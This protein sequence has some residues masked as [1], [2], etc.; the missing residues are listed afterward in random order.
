[1]G[2]Y[3]SAVQVDLLNGAFKERV[4]FSEGLN[5]VSGANG[6]GKTKLLSH[7]RDNF[8]NQA[9]VEI[10]QL[11]SLP[12][13]AT[14]ARVQAINPR[15]NSQRQSVEQI[16]NRF[17]SENK[18]FENALNEFGQ[19]SIN[20][21]T[22]QP[23]TSLAELFLLAFERRRMDGS[24][25]IRRMEEVAEDFNSVIA[26]IF[27]GYRINATWD[28]QLGRPSIRVQK[29]ATV[30]MDVDQ[31]S[32]GEQS[33]LALALHV[34]CSRDRYDVLLIDEPE[35]HLNWS[36]ERRLFALLLWLAETYDKQ[37]IV[38]THSRVVFDSE[39]ADRTIFLDWS[40]AG[41]VSVSRVPSRRL[42][43]LLAGEAVNLLKIGEF[44]RPTFFVED[45]AHEIA[46]KAIAKCLEVAV[47][48][49][50]CGSSSNVKSMYR[51]SKA[52]GG[53]RNC[54][55]VVDGDNQGN[56]YPGEAEFV[57]L[58]RYC[59][60]NYFVDADIVASLTSLTT[61]EVHEKLLSAIGKS[62][63]SLLR[64]NARF[65]GF[66]L[67]QLKVDDL[68]SDRLKNLDMSTVFPQFLKE[69]RKTDEE[70]FALEFSRAALTDGR[71]MQILPTRLVEILDAAAKLPIAKE[72]GPLG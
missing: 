63:E 23:Y 10:V 72:P 57:H 67:D 9:I 44:E 14:G 16:L 29:S 12:M 11:G 43:D 50:A 24:D 68:T 31:L 47:V 7:I 64:Q 15:R 26:R 34:Y 61:A 20:D 66:L 54:W 60:Q 25:A 62:G 32:L 58:D 37:I 2:K 42:V 41:T 46:I 38:V 40:D 65:F 19:Q 18:N 36:L 3:V 48:V 13:A 59:I 28:G 71:R 6:T 51:L 33:I 56:S 1:M 70:A 39:F 8:G 35:V 17:R 21:G 53:W 45:R 22:F 69:L 52:D 55:F 4:S 27:V 49:T 5:I 30:S